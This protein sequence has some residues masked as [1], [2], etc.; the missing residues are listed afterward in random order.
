[1]VKGGGIRRRRRSLQSSIKGI[2]SADDAE[3]FAAAAELHAMIESDKTGPKIA[4]QIVSS[5]GVEA[6]AYVARGSEDY[7]AAV[8]VEDLIQLILKGEHKSNLKALVKLGGV[9]VLAEVAATG[10]GPKACA[11][12][13][14]GLDLETYPEDL[15]KYVQRGVEAA[16]AEPA[17]EAPA[18]GSF[19]E[20]A[21]DG[22]AAA[23]AEPAAD[24][25]AS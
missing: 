9:A 19:F 8:A 7:A 18:P 24:A 1:M 2:E 5:G 23:D 17:A 13:A 3:R 11:A 20:V 14:R 4:S 21:G 12:A 22:D 16:R 15:R 25:P 6:L 10:A